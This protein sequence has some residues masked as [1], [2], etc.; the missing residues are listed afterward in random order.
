MGQNMTSAIDAEFTAL[1]DEYHMIQEGSDRQA[2]VQQMATVCR[3]LLDNRVRGNKEQ[4]TH[5][6]AKQLRYWEKE[7]G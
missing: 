5:Y 4:G 3:R 7:G 2:Y 6:W 1:L